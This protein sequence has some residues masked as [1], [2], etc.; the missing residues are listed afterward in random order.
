MCDKEDKD[1]R[2][3]QAR[4]VN[5]SPKQSELDAIAST[6]NFSK[7]PHKKSLSVDMNGVVDIDSSHPNYK[8]WLEDDK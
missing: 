1:M 5:E 4:E 7:L 2:V 3:T 8:H 6:I